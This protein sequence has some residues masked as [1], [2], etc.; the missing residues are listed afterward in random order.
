MLTPLVLGSG[1]NPPAGDCCLWTALDDADLTALCSLPR[2]A[3]YLSY[4]GPVV[5][6]HVLPRD[7][8]VDVSVPVGLARPAETLESDPSSRPTDWMARQPWL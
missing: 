2:L 7:V 6:A 3:E 1:L 8:P 4:S 5:A